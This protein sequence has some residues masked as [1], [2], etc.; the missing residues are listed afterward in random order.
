MSVCVVN[1]CL[2]ELVNC[3]L[4]ALAICVGEVIVIYLKVIV[5]FLGC[6]FCWLIRAWS[7]KEYVCCVGDPSVC[8]SVPSIC[9]IC[10]FV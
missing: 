5:L 8:L 6:V 9:Q 2:T 3:L 1:L 4:N 10:V 7:S